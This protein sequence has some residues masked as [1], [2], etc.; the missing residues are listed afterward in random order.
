MV[1]YSETSMHIYMLIILTFNLF[2]SIV[3]EVWLVPIVDKVFN[4]EIE[5]ENKSQRDKN[6]KIEL[7]TI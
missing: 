1:R 6:K 7:K 3:I 4:Q 5:P 2:L